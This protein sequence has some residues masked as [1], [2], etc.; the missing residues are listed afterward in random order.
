MSTPKPP[1]E[2]QDKFIVRLP[3][4]M[5]DR[6]KEAAEQ[7]NRSMNAE[8]VA[9][10]DEK[11]PMP[12]FNPTRLFKKVVEA[13]RLPP[14][15]RRAELDKISTECAKFG[16]ELVVDDNDHVAFKLGDTTNFFIP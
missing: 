4:G 1:S 16:V 13:R 5:R 2:I 7:N 9:A 3:D 14:D 11:F 8:V 6:I 12:V 15:E 10:L